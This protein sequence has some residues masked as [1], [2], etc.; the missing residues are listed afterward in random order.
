MID[1]GFAERLFAGRWIAGPGID[2]AVRE[3]KKF[4]RAGVKAIINYLGEEFHSKEDV[5]EATD[6]IMRA[7][8][9]IKANRIK[10]DI[11]VK[12]TQ[13]GLLVG[14]QVFLSNLR[15]LAREA[16]KAGVFLWID[17]EEPETV[18]S[19]VDAY[20]SEFAG[21][22][23]GLCV[24]SY[25]R[26]SAED[27]RLLARHGAVVRLVKGAYSLSHA[28]YSTHEEITRNYLLLMQYLFGH[29]KR[30]TLATHDLDIIEKALKLN[31]RYKRD[32]T[33]AMLKGVRN[34]YLK[35]LAARGENASV[36]IPFGD[37]WVSYSYRRLRE[38]G[39]LSLIVKSLF[40]RQ[41]V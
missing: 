29:S 16:K 31:A 30:F 5:A 32:V 15:K 33:Y 27:L 20:A 13:L 6:V 7:I 1:S 26:R 28:T 21:K 17:M 40:E 10:A 3:A 35:D 12:P 9:A 18:D 37:K 2:D 14:K 19:V 39:H 25:L 23:V 34:R 36:Y 8:S 22:E 41:G 11:S 38:A 4:N 24:Q